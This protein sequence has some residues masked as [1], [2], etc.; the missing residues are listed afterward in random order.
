M[1]QHFWA[2]IRALAYPIR[3]A[4]RRPRAAAAAI[5]LLLAAAVLGGIQYARH[6]WEAAHADLDA[7]RPREAFARMAVCLFVWPWDP[8]VH[9]YAAR[10]ARLSGD[11][12]AAEVHLNRC[13]RLRGQATHEVQLEF[14]LYRVQSGELDEVAPVLIDLVESGHTDAPTILETLARA[15][16]QRLRY[17]PAY[18]SLSRWL[19]LR[20]DAVKAYQWR[21]WVLER[22]NQAKAAAEDYHR[23]LELAPDLLLVR[24]RVAEMLLEDKRAPEAVPHLERLYRQAPENAQVQARLGICRFFEN[25]TEEARRLMEAAVVHL[26]KDPSLLI[27]L[28]RLD[29]QERRATDAEKRLRTVLQA[30]PSDTEALYTLTSVLQY[31]GRGAEAAATLKDYEHYKERVDRAN[32]LLREVG[33]STTATAADYFEVGQLFLHI[34]NDRLGVYWLERALERDSGHQATHQALAEHFDRKGMQ[35]RAASHRRLLRAPGGTPDS[36]APRAG[37]RETP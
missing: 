34:G 4:R 14:L 22:M 37:A 3:V 17:K 7:D 35:E 21:G 25:R 16:M 5:V 15:Y 19:E 27:H 6:E 20:P 33:D 11:L 26:P 9:L 1:V 10:T 2:V 13:L 8:D 18:A 12:H 24:L 32:R 30:D 23:A 36:E 29:L 28:A 31:Q